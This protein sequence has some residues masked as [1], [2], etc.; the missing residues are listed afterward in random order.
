MTDEQISQSTGE[1]EPE[2]IHEFA[3]RLA[4]ERDNTGLNLLSDNQR[5]LGLDLANVLASITFGLTKWEYKFLASVSALPSV[6]CH[7]L[8][9]VQII[10]EPGSG[11]SQL[12]TA[13]S[14]LSGQ[15]LISGQ[16]T[17]A[18][19]KNH[20]N[21]IRWVD[22]GN[23]K[24]EKNCLLLIDNLNEDSFKKDEY[25][26]SFLNGYNRETDTTYISA[27]D[28]KN[29]EFKTFCCKV[30]TTV[31]E[32]ESQELRRR[33]VTIRTT[34]TVNL[35]D[36]LDIHEIN[37]HQFK[38][39]IKLF[40][41]NPSNWETQVK[42]KEELLGLIKKPPRHSREHWT[43]LLDVLVTGLT[44]GCWNSLID[45]IED[46]TRWLDATNIKRLTF[47]EK[48]IITALESILGFPQSDWNQLSASAT[49]QVTPRHLKEAIESFVVEGVIER[50]KLTRVHQILKEVGF[51]PKKEG[52]SIVYIYIN[53]NNK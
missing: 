8:P 28:G 50:P 29:V 43:L 14:K 3:R 7:I 34:K 35:G 53:K 37:W 21:L 46:T 1:S 17:G 18:S 42:Y 11:K 24:V 6:L 45:C 27:G 5:A 41:E 49:I 26:A 19:L 4:L 10:G 12:L 40:W 22:P 52:R 2:K 51:V 33:A 44:I 20:I 13:L 16:S 30:Y 32:L 31:W 39:A 38:T 25:L 15:T 48:T 36:A 9:I 23:K 47:L